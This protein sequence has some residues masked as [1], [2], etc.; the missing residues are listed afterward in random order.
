MHHVARFR[1]FCSHNS[2][3]VFDS[4][5]EPWKEVSEFLTLPRDQRVEQLKRGWYR[6]RNAIVYRTLADGND[7]RIDIFTADQHVVPPDADRVMAHN[8]DVPSGRVTVFSLDSGETVDIGTGKFILYLRAYN[9]GRELGFENDTLSE[10]EFLRRDDLER[11]ELVF[12]PGNIKEEGVIFGPPTLE[13][14]YS[15]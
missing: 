6:N 14:F 1:F 11:Y 3:D 9:L 10:E 4:S 2:F 7:H 5:I 8:I 15:R 13:P 12:V